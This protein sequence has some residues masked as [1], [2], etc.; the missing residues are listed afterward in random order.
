MKKELIKKSGMYRRSTMS[1]SGKSRKVS[2]TFLMNTVAR[3]SVWR[4]YADG[5]TIWG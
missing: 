1:K 5:D 3:S 2:T 4:R